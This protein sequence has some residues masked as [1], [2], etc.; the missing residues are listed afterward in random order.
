MKKILIADD[1]PIVVQ[2]L[3]FIITDENPDIIVD[4]VETCRSLL[5]L[6][7]NNLYDIL[8]LDVSLPDMIGLDALVEIK[9]KY[10]KLP[11]LILSL[12]PEDQYAII[13]MKLG[14]DGYVAKKSAP[15]ELLQAIKQVFRGEKFISP[16]L[17]LRL[18]HSLGDN[19]IIKFHEKLSSREFQVMRM[20]V[21][22]EGIKNIA[23]RLVLS[24]KTVS[25][26]R[27]R[28]LQK[29][30]LQNNTDLVKYAIKNNFTG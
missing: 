4:S 8:L 28:I 3:K 12:Y 1:H 16:S 24:P 17:A 19:Q 13:S 11:V 23:G 20:L 2:G 30:D 7:N 5:D 22:G 29:L 18:A 14:A 9:R 6:L 15:A 27:S 10:P 21:E 26:Y 25:T